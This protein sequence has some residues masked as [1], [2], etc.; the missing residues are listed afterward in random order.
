MS[1]EEVT[2]VKTLAAMYNFCRKLHKQTTNKQ[3]GAGCLIDGFDVSTLVKPPFCL[4]S[5][6]Y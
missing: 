5:T 2:Q 4:V 3:N 1:R 6:P